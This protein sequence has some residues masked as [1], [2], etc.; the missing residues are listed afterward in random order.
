MGDHWRA[1]HSAFDMIHQTDSME[2]SLGPKHGAQGKR[3]SGA[4][5]GRLAGRI[6]QKSRQDVKC[7]D[8]GPFDGSGRLE[9]WMNGREKESTR[10]R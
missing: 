9:R 4:E 8:D 2:R 7:L 6:L 1:I 10:R 5:T 3:R